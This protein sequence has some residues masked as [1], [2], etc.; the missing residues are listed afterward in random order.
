MKIDIINVPLFYGCDRPGVEF[1]P[2]V[3]K[4][5]DLLNIFTKAGNEVNEKN[6]I[7]IKEI[8]ENDKFKES[9]TMK[10]LDGVVDTNEKL[11][12]EVE[13]SIKNGSL[14][15]T[16]GGDHSLGLGTVAGTTAAFDNDMAVIWIDAHADINTPETSPSGN[17]H[18]MPLGASMG[19]GAEE[20]KSIYYKGRKVNPNNV[21]ILGARSVDDGEVAL[22]DE[23]GINVWY[24][25]EIRDK[26]MGIVIK[27]LMELLEKRNAKN[28]HISFDID[29]LDSSL[30][31]GTGTPVENGMLY[32]ET[33][34]LISS[35]IET[36][37]VRSIDFVEFNP[38]RDVEN[39]TLVSSLTM[40]KA[41]AEALG[42]IK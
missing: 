12:K 29:S 13:D 24:M 17:T 22:I 30:V 11:A 41:F 28:I 26:G 20:L 6:T 42:K 37:K 39:K 32:D 9:K 15:F 40:I 7:E 21:F 8:S 16:I 23:A 35:I 33:I 2:S 19:Y 31:P 18:G 10:Y 4:E 5:N 36:K 14:P 38:K 3:L 25:E 27:E 34:K 1:G